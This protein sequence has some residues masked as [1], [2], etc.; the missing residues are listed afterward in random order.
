MKARKERLGGVG[1][2]E[3]DSREIALQQCMIGLD[4]VAMR[5][6]RR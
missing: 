1:E 4:E 2:E 3:G 5:S 6:I